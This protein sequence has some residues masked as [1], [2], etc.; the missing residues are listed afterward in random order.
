MF[1]VRGNGEVQDTEISARLIILPPEFKYFCY[2]YEAVETPGTTYDFF[3]NIS[4]NL[5]EASMTQFCSIHTN[6][7]LA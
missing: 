2:P 5:C 3:V 1:W 7:T 6:G 4:L